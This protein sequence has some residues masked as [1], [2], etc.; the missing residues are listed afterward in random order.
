M[1]CVL[2]NFVVLAT[3][4]L[5]VLPAYAATLSA[6]QQEVKN[7]IKEVYSYDPDTF[8]FGE[9]SENKQPLPM[10]DERKPPQTKYQPKLRCDFYK[11]FFVESLIVPD[12]DHLGCN[13]IRVRYPT[14]RGEDLSSATRDMPLPKPSIG[15]PV[16]QGGKAKVSVFTGGNQDFAKGRTLYFLVK[17]SNGWR[18][19]N[20]LRHEKWPESE[21]DNCATFA[22]KP[23]PE[24]LMELTPRCR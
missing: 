6:E 20:A 13:S 8:E 11:N 7:L 24:E 4:F 5:S 10:F 19:S 1:K 14:V 22:I 23:A 15:S 16:V 18:I 9:F 21:D 12:K 3:W 2:K 17:T